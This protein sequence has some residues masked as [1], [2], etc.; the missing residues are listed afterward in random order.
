VRSAQSVDTSPQAA[1]AHKQVAETY[2]SQAR[3]AFIE[4]YRSATSGIAHAWK[5][6]KGEDAALEL[7]TLEKAAYEVI[8]EAE[9]RPAWLAVPL[10]GLRGLLQPSD[11]EP[12]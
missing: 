10:Q 7:F 12:I 11:G 1:A 4:G 8:Y 3:E 9:N 6:A 5:G 2:L